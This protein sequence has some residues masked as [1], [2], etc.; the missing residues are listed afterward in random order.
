M[1]K[2][3]EIIETATG[4]LKRLT[5][6]KDISF[7]EAS[8]NK[9]DFMLKIN[10]TSFPVFTFGNVL[11]TN[12]LSL[13]NQ[14][15]SVMAKGK[16]PPILVAGYISPT[17][18]P[19]LSHDGLNFMDKFGNCHIAA[20]GLFLYVSGQKQTKEKSPTGIAFNEAGL[21]LISY[22]LADD[23]N[24]G[25]PYREISSATDLSLGTIK[26][27]IEDLNSNKF[28]FMAENKRRLMNVD[29]LTEHW[30]LAYNTVLKP[31]LLLGRMDFIRQQDAENWMNV[32]LVK[33]DE[34][35]GESAAY[36]IDG[37]LKPEILTLYRSNNI[38]ELAR[39]MKLKPSND[40]RVL[41]Y[42][43]F[44]TDKGNCNT[45]PRHIVYADL[46]GSGDS[47]CLETAKRLMKK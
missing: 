10:G 15:A 14:M 22:F 23:D 44:W 41:V 5:G 32:E 16:R 47:R 4:N 2:G 43:K 30:Q 21:K 27:V 29:T 37:F 18:I 40:G 33:G 9:H 19:D 38:P 36:L 3:T 31:K 13:K 46:M 11:K 26:N 7:T 39:G 1:N 34:W 28:I 17:L 20:K 45:A 6:L 35:G 24:V 25:K 12:Y 8:D 42:R